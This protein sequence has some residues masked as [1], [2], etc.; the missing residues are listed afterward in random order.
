MAGT[1]GGKAVGSVPRRPSAGYRS[2][3]HWKCQTI[4]TGVPVNAART[5]GAPLVQVPVQITVQKLG[6]WHP[7]AGDREH[8]R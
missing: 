2:S 5:V 1:S 8:V 6:V 3:A 4:A 7:H